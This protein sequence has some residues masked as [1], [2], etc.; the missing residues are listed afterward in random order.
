MKE[1]E[2]SGW[3]FELTHVGRSAVARDR[4]PSRGVGVVLARAVGGGGVVYLSIS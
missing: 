4:T 3:F 2:D 1:D